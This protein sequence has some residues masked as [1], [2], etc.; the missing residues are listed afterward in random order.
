MSFEELPPHSNSARNPLQRLG[1]HSSSIVEIF[2]PRLPNGSTAYM[3]M[4]RQ[5]AIGLEMELKI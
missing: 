1:R 2:K 3:L 4:E 5:R